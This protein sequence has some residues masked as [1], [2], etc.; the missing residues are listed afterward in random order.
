M[1]VRALTAQSDEQRA[2]L[3]FAR[4]GANAIKICADV[5]I[6][7]NRAKSTAAYTSDLYH[8]KT[9][10]AYVYLHFSALPFRFEG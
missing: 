8:S 3:C 2:M 5:Y 7:A 1:T 4:V 10:A 9:T 6:S